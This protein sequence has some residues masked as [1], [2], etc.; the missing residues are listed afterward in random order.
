M[1][2]NAIHE[3]GHVIVGEVLGFPTP[4]RV[5]AAV[6][7]PL[8]GGLFGTDGAGGHT[9]WRNPG[10]PELPAAA[11]VIVALAGRF[12]E[13]SF[14]I[15]RIA[16]SRDEDA[17]QIAYLLAL[18]PPGY[19]TIAGELARGLVTSQRERIARFA[20]QLETAGELQGAKVA[21]AI[22]AATAG[23]NAARDDPDRGG[24]LIGARLQ[25]RR[26][27]SLPART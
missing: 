5:W 27:G 26:S 14:G 19:G 24:H 25:P 21:Q 2:P 8:P 22:V 12:A 11:W 17:E 3:A 13:E 1:N 7:K 20:E 23:S 4:I 16:F 6:P 9:L 15:R 10:D 18:L